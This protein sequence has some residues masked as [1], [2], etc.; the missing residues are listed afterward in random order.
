M[1]EQDRSAHGHLSRRHRMVAPPL[2]LM[3]GGAVSSR[4]AMEKLIRNGERL[5]I[6][7]QPY[8]RPRPQPVRSGRY[9]KSL[10]YR[11]APKLPRR[12]VSDAGLFNNLF[13]AAVSPL[14]AAREEAH[15]KREQA[16]ILAGLGRTSMSAQ[17]NSE[18]TQTEHQSDAITEQVT[19][20][21]E[22][23][24]LIGHNID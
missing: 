5:T 13:V 17:Q 6:N 3:G 16:L 23:D 11:P 24:L 9:T 21:P 8:P 4:M 20:V 18:P 2:Q 19:V 22:S 14:Q 15:N 7:G 1:G 10:R 12:G